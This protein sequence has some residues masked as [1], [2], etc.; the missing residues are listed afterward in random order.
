MKVNAGPTGLA[1]S[2][3][4]YVHDIEILAD[5]LK[6]Q[7][8][9]G[10]SDIQIDMSRVES[11]DTAALQL[12]VSSWKYAADNQKSLQLSPVSDLVRN[13]LKLTGLDALFG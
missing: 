13:T 3:D 5:A 12:F 9:S 4:V 1:L 11:I 10:K 8:D 7:L 2:G 6:D